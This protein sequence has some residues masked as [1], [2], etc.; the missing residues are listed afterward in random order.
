[1]PKAGSNKY[2]IRAQPHHTDYGGVVWHGTYIRMESARLNWPYEIETVGVDAVTCLTGQVTLVTV[3]VERR[4]V[5]RRMPDEVR[6]IAAKVMA[7]LS[8]EQG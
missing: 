5:V 2:P 1:M 7:G 4:Q 8:V 6:A 3:D